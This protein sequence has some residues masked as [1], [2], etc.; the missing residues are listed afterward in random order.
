[1]T[2][3]DYIS[4][5]KTFGPTVALE[6]FDLDVKEGELITLLGPSGCGKTTALRI[7]AGFEFADSGALLVGGADITRPARPGRRDA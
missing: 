6:S 3:L 7:T 2:T 5:R 4:I 1:M